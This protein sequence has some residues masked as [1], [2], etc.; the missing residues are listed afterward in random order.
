MQD[1]SS[2]LHPALQAIALMALTLLA[3]GVLVLAGL[4]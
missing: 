2:R 3:T 4:Q 1:S